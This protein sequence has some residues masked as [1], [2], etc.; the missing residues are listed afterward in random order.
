[1]WIHHLHKQYSTYEKMIERFKITPRQW[2]TNHP[3]YEVLQHLTWIF[4]VNVN[5]I[6]FKR[7]RNFGEC[8]CQTS[9]CLM[10]AYKFQNTMMKVLNAQP[11]VTVMCYKKTLYVLKENYFEPYLINLHPDQY[12]SVNSTVVTNQMVYDIINNKPVTLEYNVKIYTSYTYIRSQSTKKLA[13]NI[14]AY[15]FYNNNVG[16]LHLFVTPHLMNNTISINKLSNINDN[17]FFQ[18]NMMCSYN[19]L[20]EGQK[21]FQNSRVNQDTLNQEYCICEH[22]TTNRIFPNSKKLYKPLGTYL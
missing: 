15:H 19:H 17:T 11:S 4:K 13:N 18:R 20:T 21:V 14:I 9:C 7:K 22:P 16:T 2:N 5:V 6:E 3:D 8:D 1:M 12:I 10:P